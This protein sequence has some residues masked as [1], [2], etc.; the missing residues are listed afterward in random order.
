MDL[1]KQDL[2]TLCTAAGVAGRGEIVERA[3]ELLAPLTDECRVDTMGNL[4]AVRRGAPNGRTVML[5]AHMDEIGFLVIGVDDLGFIHVASAGGADERVLAA[6][7]VV[8]YGE[9]GTYPGVFCSVPPHLIKEGGALPPIEDMGID[10]G[11]TAEQARACVRP[12][13]P[14]GFAPAFAALSDTVVSAK[15]LDDRA[16]LAAILHALRRLPEKLDTTVAVCFSVQ[17]EVGCRGAAAA[18]RQLRPD[19]ALV[20]DV[21]FAATPDASPYQCGKMN[22]GVMLGYSPI[23]DEKLG[24]ALD[25][26]AKK[27]QIPV[28]PEVMGRSTGTNADVISKENAGIPTALLSIPQRYMHTPVET[29]DVRDV[30]AVG[31]LMAAYLTEGGEQA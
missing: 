19:A 31:D 16:G 18:A 17:E 12:G 4:L 3:K 30:A 20:T 11:M 9:G 25:G 6:Q 23:L 14:V 7:P 15:S 28:Q 2:Q 10:I 21:S 1:I 29:V 8:V 26:L 13:D 22:G 5:E 24:A 27:H